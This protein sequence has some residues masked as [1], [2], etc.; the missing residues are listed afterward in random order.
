M[1]NQHNLKIYRRWAGVYDAWMPLL[2]DRAR[3]RAIETLNLQVGERLLIPGIGTGLDIPHLP[4]DISV[5]GGDLSPDMLAKARE[6]AEGRDITL[7]E[8]DI[9]SLDI[10]DNSFDAVLFNLILS[11]VPDGT[12]AFR[13]GWRTLK[14][15]GRAVI[16]DK[17]LPEDNVLTPSR[18]FIGRIAR[19]M[20]T[21][22]NRRLSEVI[23]NGPTLTIERD[24]PSLLRGQYRIL[25]VRKSK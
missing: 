19:A 6:K 7:R 16:F 10:P 21:D 11:V 4:T 8:M 1:D 25:L 17:F 22:P 9:Q 20:G 15:G 13:E 18:R 2:Y 12:L 3:R 5:V 23:G 14:P 24:E